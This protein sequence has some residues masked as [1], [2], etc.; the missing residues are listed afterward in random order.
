MHVVG[1]VV[2]VLLGVVRDLNVHV[3]AQ[4]LC[5]YMHISP[6]SELSLLYR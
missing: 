3:H 6:L 1:D 4:H 2:C 5:M